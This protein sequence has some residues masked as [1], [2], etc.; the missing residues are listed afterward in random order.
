MEHRLAG[1]GGRPAGR[2][3]HA[4][5]PHGPFQGRPGGH[6]QGGADRAAAVAGKGAGMPCQGCAR[7]ED[8]GHRLR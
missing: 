7:G 2:L 8:A 5:L 4:R 3:F 6:R 1:G